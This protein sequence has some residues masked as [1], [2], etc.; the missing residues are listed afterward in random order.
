MGK[1]GDGKVI[2]SFKFFYV[3]VSWAR[4]GFCQAWGTE[5]M[6]MKTGKWSCSNLGT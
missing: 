6:K 2:K 5:E 1:T 3:L 4:R